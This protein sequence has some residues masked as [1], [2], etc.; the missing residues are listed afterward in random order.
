ME[1]PGQII[2]FYSYKGGTGR[3]MALAN[4]A[5]FLAGQLAPGSRGVLMI[6]WDLEAPGL[7][8]YF[9]EGFEGSSRK[10]RWRPQKSGSDLRPGLI[11]FFEEAR[12]CYKKSEPG[13]LEKT[14]CEAIQGFSSYVLETGVPGLSIVKAGRFDDGYPKR[15]Q[16]FDWEGFHDKDPA[17]FRDLRHSLQKTYSF[18]LIDSRTGLTDTSG[19]CVQQM[20][21]KVVLVFVPNRQS[22]D[23]IIDVARRIRRFRIGSSD[24]RPL[25]SFPLASRIDGDNERLRRA[26]RF[27]GSVGDGELVGYQGIFE[28]LFR[29]LYEL[30]ECDL[31]DYFDSTQIKHDSDYAYGEKIAVQRGTTEMLSLGY[32]FANFAR[33]LTTLDG[34]WES[35]P[36]GA[37]IR[38]SKRREEIATQKE[39]I[40]LSRAKSLWWLAAVSVALALISAFSFFRTKEASKARSV[41]AAATA[42]ADPLEKALLL[43]SL[44]GSREPTGGLRLAL[45]VAST[46]FRWPS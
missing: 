23:G 18:V 41:L 31:S 15:I 27:G 37:E 8:Q 30:D 16:K 32:S 22:I 3:S 34:P 6:D 9:V 20:P 46:P 43:A 12:A 45:E 39:K 40:A 4:V 5:Y 24:L 21:E 26:W 29:E 19:I 11:D 10:S 35:L 1:S 2:T 36:E 17:F 14:R 42:S 28:K 13:D 38:E 44:K 7:H 33:R 25:V